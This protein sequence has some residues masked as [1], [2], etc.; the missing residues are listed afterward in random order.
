MKR[1]V[2]RVPGGMMLLPLFFGGLLRT[3]FPHVFAA[4]NTILR[5][6]FTGGPMTGAV[7]FLA[8]SGSRRPLREDALARST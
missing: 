7:P 1:W 6:S 3:L 4:D 5:T 2:D 8:A